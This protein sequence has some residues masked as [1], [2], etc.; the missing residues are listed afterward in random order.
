MP[1]EVYGLLAAL[2]A[3]SFGRWGAPAWVSRTGFRLLDPVKSLR[4]RAE[5]ILQLHDR[6]A[7]LPRERQRRF[8][9]GEGWVAWPGPAL[10]EF[11][12]QFVAHNRML[13][14]GFVIDDRLVTLAD[15]RLPDPVRRRR[16]GRDRPGRRCA[17]DPPGR[18]S[19]RGVRALPARRPLRARR[20]L[21][22][23]HDLVA[24][25]GGLDPL[26]RRAR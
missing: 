23:E 16:G 22:G 15:L 25:R 20:R 3:E 1:E 2:A 19:G 18:A 7:L 17:G 11:V 24:D 21:E 4:N 14:G 6:E 8:L 13:E 12:R 5:F 9:E 26:A 10:A